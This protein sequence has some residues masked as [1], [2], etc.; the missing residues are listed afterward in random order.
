MR[1]KCGGR[2]GEAAVPELIKGRGKLHGDRTCGEN[3]VVSELGVGVH[4]KVLIANI[5][6]ANERHGIVHDQQLIVHPVIE[7]RGVN[8]NSIVRRILLCPR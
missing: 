2:N 7:S 3:V 5:A 8:M 4:L 6:A 1:F